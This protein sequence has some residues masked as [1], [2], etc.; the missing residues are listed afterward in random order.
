MVDRTILENASLAQTQNY[1][2]PLGLLNFA[3]QESD[4]NPL[5]QRLRT[6]F[7]STSQPVGQLSGGNQQKVV[8]AKSLLD[9]PRIIIFDEPTRGVDIAAKFD[10]HTL[11]TEL[12]ASGVTVLLIS[13]DLP[14]DLGL[15]DR[16]G[17]MRRGS[18]VG[19]LDGPTATQEQVVTLASGGTA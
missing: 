16:V 14:E 18:M 8:L 3:K 4:V 9:I 5:L 6:A 17:V 7:R 10:V 19:I 15:S 13:S 1:I 11:V 12:A 2:G